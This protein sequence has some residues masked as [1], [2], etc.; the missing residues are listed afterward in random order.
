MVYRV[1]RLLQIPIACTVHWLRLFLAAGI[2]LLV[3][4]TTAAARTFHYSN[5]SYL[6]LQQQQLCV[7]FVLYSILY[8]C[9]AGL[10]VLLYMLNCCTAVSTALC[11]EAACET[12]LVGPIA[13]RTRTY[14]CR[15]GTDMNLRSS[16]SNRCCSCWYCP[17]YVPAVLRTGAGVGTI[18]PLCC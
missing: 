6:P 1:L 12:P 7:F 8:S 16:L 5:S 17:V 18:F 15:I 4:S 11:E 3:P 10:Y 14:C 9:F 13:T 2:A